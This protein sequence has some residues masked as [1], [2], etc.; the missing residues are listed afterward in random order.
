[1]VASRPNPFRPHTQRFRPWPD[2]SQLAPAR[3][4]TQPPAQPTKPHPVTVQPVDTQPISPSSRL[5]LPCR[6]RPCS[7]HNHSALSHF[8]GLLLSHSP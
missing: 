6:T 5:L 7:H 8:H 3:P 4:A 2:A 1:M